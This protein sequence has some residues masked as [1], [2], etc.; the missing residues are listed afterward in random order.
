MGKI[1][2]WLLKNGDVVVRAGELV[3]ALG[4]AVRDSIKKPDKP[5]SK[6]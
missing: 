2:Q 4:K 5:K 6:G 1:V 3:I